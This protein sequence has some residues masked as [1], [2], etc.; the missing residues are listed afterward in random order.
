MHLP[1]RGN[2]D[3]DDVEESAGPHTRVEVAALDLRDWQA[4][5]AVQADEVQRLQHVVAQQSEL[6]GPDDEVHRTRGQDFRP[7]ARS[8]A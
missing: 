8:K 4:A 5:R 6:R 7:P 1:D 2:L 3:I